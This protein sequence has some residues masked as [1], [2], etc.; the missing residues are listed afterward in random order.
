MV[1]Q[2]GVDRLESR[3]RILRRMSDEQEFEDFVRQCQEGLGHQVRG[4]S[5]P[6]LELWSRSDDVVILGAVG[7][8]AQ[9][10]DA[11]RTHI[12]GAGRTLDWSHLEVEGITTTLGEELGVSVALE[13]MSREP[14]G[15]GD[16]RT[17]RAT[18]VYRREGDRWRL[19]LRHANTVSP[20]DESRERS[21]AAAPTDPHAT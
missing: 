13:H 8:Y 10:W 9:G 12:L 18:Q 2:P 15:G 19:I 5:A 21:L 4:D 1:N 3:A 16:T 7:S 14:D 20:D 6:F 17:L 11:V